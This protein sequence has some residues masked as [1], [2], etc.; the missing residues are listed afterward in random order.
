[1]HQKSALAGTV[2]LRWLLAV[3]LDPCHHESVNLVRA[4]PRSVV[5]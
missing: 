1:M 2:T 3:A 5:A 4:G